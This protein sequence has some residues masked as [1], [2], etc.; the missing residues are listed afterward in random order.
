MLL[1]MAAGGVAL[2]YWGPRTVGTVAG[3]LNSTT[4]IFWGWAHLSGRLPEPAAAV[5]R[6]TAS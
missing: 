2:E 6:E 3:L 1:S 5:R 4:A